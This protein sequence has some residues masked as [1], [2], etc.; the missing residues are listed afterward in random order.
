M[1]VGKATES[2]EES[3]S[4]LARSYAFKED[5]EKP[6]FALSFG[7]PQRNISPPLK[8]LRV[9]LNQPPHL[10]YL[11]VRRRKIDSSFMAYLPIQIQ[12][13]NVAFTDPDP[14]H[15]AANLQT[16]RERCE[17]LITFAKTMSPLHDRRDTLD[18]SDDSEDRLFNRESMSKE[19]LQ[20]WESF[21]NSQCEGPGFM[22]RKVVDTAL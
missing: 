17:K 21:W 2:S 22:R 14:Q 5:P 9:M 15:L 11:Q 3:S 13:L 18:D 6:R 1:L 8:K 12:T 20:N 7:K 10:I 16:M 19:V 4:Y